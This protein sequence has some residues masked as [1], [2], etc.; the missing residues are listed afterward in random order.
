MGNNDV[1]QE[2]SGDSVAD[3]VSHE[4]L[5]TTQSLWDRAYDALGKDETRLVQEYEKLLLKEG[6]T[7]NFTSNHG[8]PVQPTPPHDVTLGPNSQSRQAQLNTVMEQGLQRMEEKKARYTIAGHEFVLTDQIAQAAGFVLWAKDW[9]GD[10]VKASPEASVGWAGVCMILPLLTNPKT[11]EDANRGGFTYVTTRMRY[12]AALEPLLLRLGQDPGVDNDLM[13]EANSHITDLYQHILE[14]QIRSVL[15]FY[16][17]CL[18][19]Y[20]K[21]TFLPREWKQMR[22]EIEKLEATVNGNLNQ[23]NQ[24]TKTRTLSNKHFVL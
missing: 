16:Q 1:Q 12:Y 9:I 8:S 23:I 15:R 6:Q 24:F 5:L 19:G 18:K 20:A 11:T 14:F 3:P 10:A 4:E 22:L 17:G 7:T 21:D 13:A 2:R